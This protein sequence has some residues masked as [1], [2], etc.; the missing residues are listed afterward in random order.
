MGKADRLTTHERDTIRA[1]L[2]AAVRGPYFPDWE[3]GTLIG[4]TRPEVADLLATWPETTD[5]DAQDLAVNNVL[6]NLLAYPHG[7][8]EALS[9]DVE[10]SGEELRA[11]LEHWRSA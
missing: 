8:D 2:G 3:F 9:R 11:I 4:L 7:E 10:V 5:P 6:L 1:A